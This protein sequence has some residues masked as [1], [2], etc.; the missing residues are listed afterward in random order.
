MK[1]FARHITLVLVA[2]AASIAPFAVRAQMPVQLDSVCRRV[3]APDSAD[4]ARLEKKHFWRAT[5]EVAGIDLGIWAFDCYVTHRDYAKIDFR[6]I[7]RNLR[8]GINWDADQLVTNNFFHPY[9]GSLFYESARANGFNFYESALFAAAGSTIWE[10]FLEDNYPSTNDLV[11]TPV[12][13][14]AVGEVLYRA[15][16][17]L[18][19][20]TKTGW[21]RF[22]CEFAG[23]ILAPMREF[24]RIVTGQAWRH[25]ATPGRQFGMPPF[26]ITLSAGAKGMVFPGAHPYRRYAAD[27]M[28]NLEYGDRFAGHTR[29]PYDYFTLDAE[30]NFG[31][32]TRP[33]S[34]IYIHGRLWDHN[35]IEQDRDQLNIGIYQDFDFCDDRFHSKKHTPFMYAL[36]AAVSGSLIYRHDIPKQI[37]LDAYAQLDAVGLG[38]V[39]TDHFH[40]GNRTYN[41]AFGYGLKNGVSLLFRNGAFN[42][43]L[44]NQFF[45]LFT[46][47]GY[48]PET[49]LRD[50]TYRTM[51]VMG[52]KGQTL[53]DITDLRADI[54]IWKPLYATFMLTHNWRHSSYSRFPNVSSSEFVAR[55][56]LTWR[57]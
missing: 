12:G 24:N 34:G 42:L 20:D 50:Q 27:F 14:A 15:A 53:L 25:S 37:R 44:N 48:S 26:A 30:F 7:G 29:H 32:F 45:Q 1:L 16:D 28:F 49:N 18:T 23:A 21:E 2:L 46:P 40:V 35:I 51:N 10:L 19:D 4:V 41:Y 57:F 54:R 6:T 9:N 22:G 11:A 52:D 47:S 36:P 33:I 31:Q 13:G 43:S 55:F 38:C 17:A 8:H 3:E 39:T 56:L 5:A